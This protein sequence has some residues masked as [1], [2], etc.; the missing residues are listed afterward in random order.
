MPQP[1]TDP[2]L[3]ALDWVVRTG[4]PDFADWDAFTAWL[5]ADPAHAARYHALAAEAEAAA[6]LFPATP[7]VDVAPVPARRPAWRRPRWAGGAIAAALAGVIGWQAYDQR[8][9]PYAIETAP[10]RTHVVALADGS[11]IT[12]NGGTR[13]TLDRRDPRR[14]TLDRGQALFAVRHDAD[15]PFRVAVGDSELVDIGTRFDVVRADAVTRVAVS[16]GAVLFNPERERVRLDP[17]QA[18]R[19]ADG[20]GHYQRVAVDP[21]TVGGWQAGRLDYDGAPLSEVAADI[22]RA[23]GARLTVAAG[24]AARPFRGTILLDGIAVD[25]ARLGPLLNVRMVQ[26]GDH[27][28][29]N[30]RP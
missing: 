27:W 22:G 2:D 4:D 19:V 8:A 28:E 3:A 15:R 5:E 23:T 24:I 14:A 7:R 12:L 10:G 9:Q 11:S 6:A 17:G 16:E 1:L 20:A 30:A 29:L 21:A 26:A 25:P 18:L 13:M